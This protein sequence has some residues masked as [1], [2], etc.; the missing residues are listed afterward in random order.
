MTLKPP[1]PS[2]ACDELPTL[3]AA[4]DRRFPYP[5]VEDSWLGFAF[6]DLALVDPDDAFTKALDLD[7]TRFDDGASKASLLHWIATRR[8]TR[9]GAKATCDLSTSAN[10]TALPWNAS[11]IDQ[12]CDANLA[13]FALGLSGLC[14]PQADGYMFGCCPVLKAVPP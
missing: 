1:C 13:C 3:L 4:V 14:C 6:A 7:E 2:Q 12:T 5:P 8:A 11:G 9:N 10:V